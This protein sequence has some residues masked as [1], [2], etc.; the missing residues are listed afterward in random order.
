[1]NKITAAALASSLVFASSA[2]AGTTTTPVDVQ[3]VTDTYAAVGDTTTNINIARPFNVLPVAARAG[4]VK[5]AFE[6]TLSA[7]VIGGITDN[8]TNS[9]MGVIAGSTKGYNVF[10]G[11]SVGGS[12]TQCGTTVEKDVDFLAASEVVAA[13]LVLDNDNACGRD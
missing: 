1:M 6:V 11:S 8:N 4:F 13:S 7:N 2:F 3:L 12:V 10:T 9:R 5:N